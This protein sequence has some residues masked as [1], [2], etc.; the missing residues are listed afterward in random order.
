MA[1]TALYA[2]PRRPQPRWALPAH[3]ID[4]VWAYGSINTNITN[5][6]N[7]NIAWPAAN[8]AIY[9]PVVVK[10]M[11]TVRKLWFSSG[12]TGTG[13]IDMGIYSRAGA[14]VIN[15][16]SIAK[17]TAA[18]E[19]VIDITDT[20]LKPDLYYLALQGS[21]GTDTFARMT[22]AA[23]AFAAT[24][25]RSQAVGSFGLPSTATWTVDQTLAYLPLM[26]ML[27]VTE[28]S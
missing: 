16:G 6:I 4:N 26:G 17:G 28:V 19:Q 12:T 9:V 23:P 25:V 3:S 11:V 20:L 8:F 24:G 15:S 27:L 2:D 5:A 13:N 18:T 22:V 21:N 1:Y 7:T 14:R 10:H